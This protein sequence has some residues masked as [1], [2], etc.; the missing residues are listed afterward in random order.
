MSDKK[1]LRTCCCGFGRAPGAFLYIGGLE[2]RL[3][4][5]EGA[6][7]SHFSL[8]LL[9]I[10]GVSCTLFF[11]ADAKARKKVDGEKNKQAV[12]DLLTTTGTILAVS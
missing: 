6:A 3:E 7:A 9:I 11:A 4:S 5:S 8:A 1:R 12:V 10:T 2:Y